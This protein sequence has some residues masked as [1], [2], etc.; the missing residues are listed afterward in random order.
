[1]PCL[2]V[3]ELLEQR[4][5]ERSNGARVLEVGAR[6]GVEIDPELVGV[7]RIVGV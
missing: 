4:A 1:M 2:P 7:H 3:A 6:G 5:R